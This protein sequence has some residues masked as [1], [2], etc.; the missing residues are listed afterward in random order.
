MPNQATG[1]AAQKATPRNTRATK[2]SVSTAG[3]EKLK[4]DS[5]F[6]PEKGAPY[7]TLTSNR[8]VFAAY[9]IAAGVHAGILKLGAKTVTGKTGGNVELFRAILGGGRQ[10]SSARSHWE[11][12]GRLDRGDGTFTA[13]GLSEM[14]YR[15]SGAGP[16]RTDYATVALMVEALTGKAV[17]VDGT[18]YKFTTEIAISR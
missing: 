15:I 13:K 16:Y 6:V 2:K 14:N 12:I 11:R 10:S 1:K 3:A 9:I 5:A 18:E 7:S 8:S 4:M 17:K